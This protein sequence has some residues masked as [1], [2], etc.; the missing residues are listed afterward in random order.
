MKTPVSSINNTE[1]AA[2]EDALQRILDHSGVSA[3]VALR[4][5]ILISSVATNRTRIEAGDS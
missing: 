2:Y 4:S 1:L 3:L 5:C